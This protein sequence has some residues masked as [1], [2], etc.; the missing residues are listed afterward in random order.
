VVAKGGSQVEE[1]QTEAENYG[2]ERDKKVKTNE[3]DNAD[4]DEGRR[5]R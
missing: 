3:N 5:S 4:D 1:A 2:K